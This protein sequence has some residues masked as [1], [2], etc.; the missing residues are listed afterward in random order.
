[1]YDETTAPAGADDL[2]TLDEGPL[3]TRRNTLQGFAW[4]APAIVVARAVPA[5]AGS[6][7]APAGPLPQ[8]QG[9]TPTFNTA[10][11][12]KDHWVESAGGKVKAV[13][14][15]MYIQNLDP[16]Q[17][18]P[19]S[20][21]MTLTLVV[22][23]RGGSNHR[24]GFGGEQGIPE[25]TPWTLASFS[26]TSTHATLVLVY[27]GPGMGAWGGVSLSNLWIESQGSTAGERIEATINATYRNGATSSRS[28]SA[29]L[30]A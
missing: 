30:A 21:T 26:T 6:G 10:Q 7:A 20:V 29:T 19:A 3:L 28:D 25:R 4:A 18:V 16:N 9:L 11:Y 2:R 1:M 8:G 22:P 23:I 5:V 27:T 14:A 13:V 12:A 15:G 17:G 24:W